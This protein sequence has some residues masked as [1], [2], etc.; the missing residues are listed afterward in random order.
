MAVRSR[1]TT[2]SG[3]IGEAIPPLEPEYTWGVD[4]SLECYLPGGGIL[5][6]AGFHRWVYNV[7]YSNTQAV[8]TTFQF[9][10]ITEQL[11]MSFIADKSCFDLPKSY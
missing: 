4:A 2:S 10:P 1:N 3:S 11:I 6:A 9:V 8:G 7:F 5:S